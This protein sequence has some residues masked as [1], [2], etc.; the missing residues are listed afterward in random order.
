MISQTGRGRNLRRARAWR[1]LASTIAV[2][3]AIGMSGAAASGA[4]AK[5]APKPTNGG[6]LTIA[7]DVD[8]QPATFFSGADPDALIVSLV[9]NTLITYPEVGLA[10]QPSLATSWKYGRGRTSLT[11]QLRHGVKYTNGQAFT[12]KDVAFSIQTIANPKW[13]AQLIRTAAAITGINTSKRYQ[14]TLKFAHPLSNIFDLLSQTP[15]L[16]AGTIAGFT[17]GTGYVGTGPFK[18]VSWTPG[19]KIIFTANKGYWG[20]K[21][22]LAGV[23]LSVDVTPQTQV[24]E[25]RSGQLDVALDP[26]GQDANSLAEDSQFKVL[27]LGNEGSEY[28]GFNVSNPTLKSVKLRQAIA[29]AIDRKRIASQVIGGGAVPGDLPWPTTS[30]AYSAKLNTKY[31][32]N[33]AKAK[34]L[35]SSLGSIPTLPIQFS[36]AFANAQEVAEV[37]QSDLQAV[38]LHTTL[39]PLQV[40]QFVQDLQGGQFTALWVTAAGFDQFLPATLVTAAYPFNAAKN[41]SNFSSATY[42][43]AANAAWLTTSGTSPG[44]T[45]AYKQLDNVL[46]N[47]LFLAEIA[48]YSPRIATTAKLQDVSWG[49]EG[50][51]LYLDDAYLSH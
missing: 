11:L 18:F 8:N 41:A 24:S 5:T 45:K 49:K 14:V 30:P 48:V 44:A 37:I 15:M 31:N 46:L 7:S 13:N 16:E 9:Y 27:A 6:V 43:H 47:N 29:Y 1:A 21:P 3:A 36:P 26:L 28:L 34:Q 12:S 50:P 4:N 33:V 17:S 19:Q 10:P 32:L 51:Q 40:P 22:H 20:S 35:V 39:D 38:G 25:L 2:A 42:T 23:D